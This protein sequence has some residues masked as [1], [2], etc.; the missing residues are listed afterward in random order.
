ERLFLR[1]PL[2]I[3]V[4]AMLV[5]VLIALCIHPFV[6]S[7]RIPAALQRWLRGLSVLR[8]GRR[9]TSAFVCVSAMKVAEALAI[10]AVQ[11]AV[12]LPQPLSH[13]VVVLA[14]VLAGTAVSLV[15]GNVG[16]YEAA[17]FV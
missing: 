17:A 16:T 5:A 3:A 7:M 4:G 12:G 13:V 2:A 15:P 14:A 9:A 1:T 10:A 11:H 8:D 6:G